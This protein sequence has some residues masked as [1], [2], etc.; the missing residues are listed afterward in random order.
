MHQHVEHCRAFR[1]RSAWGER[2]NR[3][4]VERFGVIRAQCVDRA[5]GR[6][7]EECLGQKR[8]D[9]ES[10]RYYCRRDSDRSK[11]C[12][13]HRQSQGFS[14]A[15][16][17]TIPSALKVGLLGERRYISPPAI[18]NALPNT[19]H[20]P[21]ETG[22]EVSNRIEN[23]KNSETG[24]TGVAQADSPNTPAAHVRK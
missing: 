21:V 18:K 24:T 8:S 1:R 20:S 14:H 11:M 4:P 10:R 6:A 23:A 3:G 17:T 15:G 12:S 13:A 2:Q 16:S 9:P 5:I 22:N 7:N 19:L